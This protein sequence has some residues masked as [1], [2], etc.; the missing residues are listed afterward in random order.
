MRQQSDR[1][2]AQLLRQAHKRVL[3]QADVLML[4]EKVVTGLILNDPLNNIVIV[5][6]NKTRHLIN[7]LQIERFARSIGHD[8]VIFPA[9]YSHTKREGGKVILQKDLFPIQ[10]GDYGATDPGLLYYCKGMPVA[11]LTNRCTALGMVNGVRSTMYGIITWCDG[12]SPSTML[13]VLVDQ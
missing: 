11:L 5:Q 1:I 3:T 4:N 12:K 8:I 6:W 13:L 2:F 9:Q 7:R 10:D